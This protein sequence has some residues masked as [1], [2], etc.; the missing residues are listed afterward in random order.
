MSKRVVAI[1]IAVIVGVLCF[2]ISCAEKAPEPAEPHAVGEIV[3]VGDWQTAQTWLVNYTA[4]IEPSGKEQASGWRVFVKSAGPCT[5]APTGGGQEFYCIVLGIE[6]TTAGPGALDL[7]T[8]PMLVD[9]KGI[10]HEVS[11]V[12][13]GGSDSFVL[14]A[15][16]SGSSSSAVQCSFSA[17]DAE[18][19][20]RADCELI[21]SVLSNGQ[22][23][24]Q[25]LVAVGAGKT[26]ELEIAFQVSAGVS[27]WVLDWPDETR[28]ALP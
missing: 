12:R 19:R 5:P 24:D 8:G 15:S 16:Q 23:F 1:V 11:G 10:K 14:A 21:L 28:F 2:C 4:E 27:G 26:V 6:N 7:T 20:Q 9:P 22:T 18:G 13:L 17:P 3:E 25:A